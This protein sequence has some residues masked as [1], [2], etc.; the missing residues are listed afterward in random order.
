MLAAL[1]R[2]ENQTAAKKAGKSRWKRSSTKTKG[3]ILVLATL[4]HHHG[5]DGSAGLLDSDPISEHEL[6]KKAG[7][8][9][10]TV[11]RFFAK[12][13]E[14]GYKGYEVHCQ[15]KALVHH[16]KLLN[17]DYSDRALASMI[18]KRGRNSADDS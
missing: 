7:C 18:T 17:G 15:S 4:S 12:C 16:L 1:H 3:D 5:Y 10:A 11:C 8:S 13:F 14:G 6:A 2:A 9:V